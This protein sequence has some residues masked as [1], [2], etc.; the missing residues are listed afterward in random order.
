MW[1]HFPVV[2]GAGTNL[3]DVTREKR[4]LLLYGNASF[5]PDRHG[6]NNG[7]LLLNG[8]DAYGIIPDGRFFGYKNFSISFYVY[9]E[10]TS[11]LFIGKQNYETAFGATFNVGFDE[12]FNGDQLRFAIT[13]NQEGICAA[14]AAGSTTVSTPGEVYLNKWVHVTVVNEGTTMRLYLDGKLAET[15][16]HGKTI[17]LCGNSEFVIGSW[18][19]GDPKFFQGRFDD[20]RIYSRPLPPE[21]IEFIAKNG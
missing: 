18:W 9:P 3:T 17:S 8:E 10:A 21:E 6:G 15:N 2:N 5:G 20:I 14:E 13:N 16:N 4:K 12:V 1:A 7:S 11:G 19:Q